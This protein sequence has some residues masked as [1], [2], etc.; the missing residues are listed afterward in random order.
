MC[1]RSASRQPCSIGSCIVVTRKRPSG[2]TVAPR[3]EPFHSRNSGV[4]CWRIRKPE[5]GA[6]V[7]RDREPEAFRQEGEAADGRGRL[8]FAQSPCACANAVLPADQATAPLGP[9]R[10]MIDPAMLRVGGESS[11]L[12]LGIGR[13]HFAVVAAADDALLVGRRGKDRAVVH[14][15]APRFAF[16]LDEQ[17]R[18]LAE[19]EHGRVAEKMRG[20]DRRAGSDGRVRSAM[21]TVSARVS[22]MSA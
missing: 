11:A 16:R 22:V 20:H 9:E 14:G 13:D 6:V 1:L 21:E 17:H 7:V 12:A 3:C 15:D 5:R 4:A 8:E 2:L 19:H 18:L 10:D